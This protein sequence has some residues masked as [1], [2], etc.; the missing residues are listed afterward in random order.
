MAILFL[1]VVAG[2]AVFGGLWIATRD[3]EP[4]A[5]AGRMDSH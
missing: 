4:A 1:S 5:K 2:L 3:N